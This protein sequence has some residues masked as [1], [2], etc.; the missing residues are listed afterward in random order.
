MKS[1][2]G[3]DRVI[4][5]VGMVPVSAWKIDNSPALRPGEARVRLRRV[6]IDWD[7][8]RQ[9]CSSCAY[10][11]ERVRAKSLYVVQRRGKLHNPFTNSGGTFSGTI[12][13]VYDGTEL[14]DGIGCG[15]E[16]Y[17]QSSLAGIPLKIQRIDEVDYDYGQ[18]VC[19]GTAIIFPTTNILRTVHDLSMNYTLAALNIGEDLYRISRMIRER[20]MSRVLIIGRDIHT[21]MYYAEAIRRTAVE[22]CGV[23]V[24]AHKNKRSGISENEIRS[25]LIPMVRHLYFLDLSEPHNAFGYLLKKEFK[26]GFMDA[27]LVTDN[28]YGAETLAA[29]SVRSHGLLYFDLMRNNSSNAM[30][31]AEGLGKVVSIASPDNSAENYDRFTLDLLR[32]MKQRLEK[33]NAF[34]RQRNGRTIFRDSDLS[35][36]TLEKAAGLEEYI[37][38]SEVSRN[39]LRN[40]LNVA[41]FD[42]NV[43]IQ[44]ETGVGKEKILSLIHQNSERRDGPC[45]RINCSTIPEG[46]AESEFFGYEEGAFTGAVSGGKKGFFEIADGGILFLDEI[47]TLPLSMQSKLLRVLQENQ[48]YRVGGTQQQDVDVRLICASNIALKDLVDEGEFRE[49]L[50]YRLNICTIE[51]PPLRERRSDIAV[52]AS[53]FVEEWNQRYRISKHLTSDAFASLV[54]YPWPGN[55]RE[56]ENVMHRLVINTRGAFISGGDVDEMLNAEEYREVVTKLRQEQLEETG[57]SVNYYEIMDAQEKRLIEYAL[58]KGGTTRRAAEI[59]GLSHSTFARK[60]QKHGL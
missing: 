24:V 30:L 48:F 5:P 15:D 49:D 33:L 53:H 54:S 34:Y 29:L 37:F 35:D 51:V 6:H 58:T 4:E 26:S 12:E 1:N 14:P 16:V 50:Y 22:G 32:G 57:D 56:L 7:S 55:V 18:I 59:I 2:Y 44:G 21:V 19:D 52:L 39:L 17:C 47:G 41:C 11:D 25:M 27:V 31:V 46:L 36:K 42:C 10:D 23:T 60:K 28:V 40:V 9:I 13:E 45:V 20:R 8:F 3:I 38:E 43:I